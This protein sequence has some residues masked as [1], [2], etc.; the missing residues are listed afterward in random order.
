M[1]RFLTCISLL[2]M[3]LQSNAAEW[4]KLPSAPLEIGN[5]I[6]GAVDNNLVIAGGITWKNDTKIFLSDIW[7]FQT[8][9]KTW[10]K[11]G[12]L[13][14]PLAYAAFGQT[15]NGLYF[16]GG[17][18]GTNLQGNLCL[19]HASGKTENLGK[20]S[21]PLVYSASAILGSKLF[22]IAGATD[23]ADLKTAT[24]G[25]YSIDLE[26]G[27]TETLPP[28]P[29]GRWIV[30]TAT[31]IGDQV[32]VFTGAYQ[33]GT[34]NAV[35][36]TDA[37]F[38]YS[39][40]TGSWKTLKSYPHTVR[41]MASCALDDHRILLAGGY[42]N[43]FTDATFIYDTKTDSY[44]KTTPLPYPAMSAFIRAGEYLYWIGG[45]DKMRHRS[46]LCYRIRWK[47]L[48]AAAKPL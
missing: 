12:T 25:F 41:G 11:T 35:I 27:K 42:T 1:R 14:Q 45:E 19:L 26:N 30:P 2:Y 44:L 20:I 23:L 39:L 29:G 40:K 24:N 17:S 28:F 36:N 38:V 9:E 13:P 10:K 18:D 48:I 31:A 47:D 3:S 8:K 6:G 33:D 4:E 32:F 15:A 7:T 46:D 37:A 21:Q 43:E 5:F 16:A 34:N 22:V